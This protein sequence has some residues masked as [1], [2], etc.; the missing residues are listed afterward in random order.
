MSASWDEF[1]WSPSGGKCPPDFEPIGVK[2]LGL[3]PHNITQY[4]SISA[5]ITDG[6]TS[7]KIDF[8]G[9]PS[10]LQVSLWEGMQDALCGKRGKLSFAATPMIDTAKTDVCPSG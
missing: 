1:T 9:M 7:D 10:R 8:P 5:D 6:E 4:G 3:L 2:W